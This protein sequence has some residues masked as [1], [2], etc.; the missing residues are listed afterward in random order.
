M[1]IN[2]SKTECDRCGTCCRKGGPAL[3]HDDRRLLRSGQLKYQ[4]L[5][6]IRQG[7]PV[8]LLA[9]VH[10]EPARSEIVKIKGSGGEW[11]CLFYRKPDA[12][13]AIYKYRPIECSLLKCWDTADL[14]N[15]AAINLLSRYDILAPEDPLLPL[16]KTHDKKCSPRHLTQLL[17]AVKNENAHQEAMTELTELVNYDLELRKRACRAFHL[18]LDCELFYFGRPLLTILMQFG[19][20]IHEVKGS[21][22]RYPPVPPLQNR[23]FHDTIQSAKV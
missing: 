23:R 12:S 3:H 14:E 15:I 9:N 4:H 18:S 10:S 20:K 11:T 2:K 16:I 19:L 1:P 8:L 7:E 5:I 22:S 21:I 17:A 6:T 13:C